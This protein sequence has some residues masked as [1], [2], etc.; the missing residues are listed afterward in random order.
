MRAG[1]DRRC[2]SDDDEKLATLD[3]LLVLQRP[4]LRNTPADECSCQGTHQSTRYTSLNGRQDRRPD[5]ACN[6]D[7]PKLWQYQKACSNA[8]TE[9]PSETRP[10]L[11][12]DLS[13]VA[14]ADK[15]D[16]FLA[17]LNVA[18][19][20]R[21]I[22]E[23]EPLFVQLP[24]RTFGCSVVGINC[25]HAGDD[26]CFCRAH[27]AHLRG[28]KV[29]QLPLTTVATDKSHLVR[30]LSHGQ[31]SAKDGWQIIRKIVLARGNRSRIDLST[32]G[33]STVP[34]Y[35]DGQALVKFRKLLYLGSKRRNLDAK[36]EGVRSSIGR[37]YRK[38]EAPCFGKSW[39]IMRLMKQVGQPMTDCPSRAARVHGTETTR[40]GG[41]FCLRG[42]HV[43]Q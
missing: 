24:H 21:E 11:R 5:G 25:D 38:R 29:D 6:H 41:L 39:H 14:A 26:R 35:R 4:I 22:V 17:L 23:R 16:R 37:G 36:M 3:V 32:T 27:I 13:I 8:Q 12:P 33:R 31:P 34:H 7:K 2:G 19:H 18:A 15:P 42:P 20:D 43:T 28:R 9:Q 1:D 30:R 10:S 40:G